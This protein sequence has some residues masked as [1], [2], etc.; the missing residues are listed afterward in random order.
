MPGHPTTRPELLPKLVLK[1][2]RGL[3][4]VPPQPPLRPFLAG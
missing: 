2:V 1:T 4:I 3:L